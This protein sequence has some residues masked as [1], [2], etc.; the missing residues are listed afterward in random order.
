MWFRDVNVWPTI[1]R[2]IDQL[3]F[4][5][6]TEISDSLTPSGVRRRW[7]VYKRIRAFVDGVFPIVSNYGRKYMTLFSGL[8]LPRTQH[9]FDEGWAACRVRNSHDLLRVLRI[10]LEARDSLTQDIAYKYDYT[11]AR[12]EECVY[13]IES[14]E[15]AR[16]LIYV[17]MI[18]LSTQLGFGYTPKSCVQEE[19]MRK[20]VWTPVFPPYSL[21]SSNTATK[22]ACGWCGAKQPGL[23]P[24]FCTRV[25]VFESRTAAPGSIAPTRVAVLGNG[26]HDTPETMF[27]R[28]RVEYYIVEDQEKTVKLNTDE[29]ICDMCMSSNFAIPFQYLSSFSP[30]RG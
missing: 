28:G 19:Y 14:L 15:A 25:H 2:Q 30:P 24:E 13:G 29:C 26:L 17:P 18:E 6:H 27:S 1:S 8:S 5:V 16:Q 9:I 3:K 7:E 20:E 23:G 10:L 12:R 22:W 21:G 11:L 4:D